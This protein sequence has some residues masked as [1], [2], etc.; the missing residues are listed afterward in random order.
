[1]S[2]TKIREPRI[3]IEAEVA[4][5]FTYASF[6]NAIP[7]LQA[8]RIGNSTSVA[9]DGV[10]TLEAKP[11]FLCSKSWL[12]DR[13]QA[14][15]SFAIHDRRVELDPSYLDGLNEAERGELAF[16][17][18]KDGV[19]LAEWA[20]PIRLLARDEW[21]GASDMAQL[22]PAFV[23]PNDP[24]IATI[25]K[26]AADLL[27]KA[28]HR[29][30]LDGYQSHDPNRVGMMV[31]AVYVAV[32]NRRLH[33]AEPPASFEQY[34]QKI[35]RPSVI[36]RDGLATCLDSSLLLASAFE[37]AGL[38]SMVL[39][40]ERHAAVGAWLMPRTL[41]RAVE[42]DASE[43]RKAVAA[44][45]L[46]ILE[47]TGV[48]QRPLVSMKN[49]RTFA[50]RRISESMAK[51][52]V[53]AIDIARSR[54][55]GI[56]PL[57]SH[58]MPTSS[59]T[60]APE[61]EGKLLPQPHIEVAP[62][63]ASEPKPAT[64]AGRM[65]RWRAK[66][67][68]LSLRNRLLNFVQSKK[69]LP[70]LC[71]DIASL[72]DQLA[73]G[74]AIRIISLPEQ[75]PLG[76]RD[77][78]FYR[79]TRR[80]DLNES[81]ATDALK[82]NE[83][84][85]PLEGT[86]LEARL[87]SLY[88]EAKGDLS[89]GGTNTLFLA[90]GFLRWR[91]PE[92]DRIYSAPL[93][94]IPVK[95]DRKAASSRFYLKEHE[96]E[97]RFNA[98]LAQFLERD[99]QLRLSS[100]DPL[101]RDQSGIDVPKVLAQIRHEIR[102]VPG[103]EVVDEVALSTF[104]FAKYLMWKDLTDRVAALRENRLVKHLIDSP[105]Q[106]F[107][108]DGK[109]F[110]IAEE[111]DRHYSPADILTPLPAD[112]SQVAAILA[113]AEGK[114][115][116]LIGPP[117]TGKSQTITNMIASCLAAGKTVLFV[118][119]KT[120]ALDVVYRRLKAQGLSRHC[121]ELHSNKSDRKHFLAQLKTAWIGENET[122]ADGW[123]ALTNGL[124]LQR[125]KLNSYADAAHRRAPNGLSV[126]EALG[127][128]LEASGEHAPE[129]RWP[130]KDAHDPET[131]AKLETLAASLG[132][133][134]QAVQASDALVEVDVVEWTLAL[135]QTIVAELNAFMQT[136]DVLK[137]ALQAFVATIGATR[138]ADPSLTGLQRYANFAHT[139]KN[140]ASQNFA[141]I[142]DRQFGQLIPAIDALQ[143]ALNQYRRCE[144]DLAAR[145]S[146]DVL[147]RIPTDQ[148]EQQWHEAGSS[149]WLMSWRRK[150]KIKKLL[151]SYAISG[152]SDPLRDLPLIREMQKTITGVQTNP[153]GR[154]QTHFRGLDT[155]A[156]NLHRYLQEAA[157]L[158]DSLIEIGRIGGDV[159]ALASRLYPAFTSGEGYDGLQ[160]S[161]AQY[162]QAH[163]Q[164]K[165]SALRLREL[166]GGD[167]LSAE[168]NALLS[169]SLARVGRIYD[170]RHKLRDWASW[171]EFKRKANAVGL[172]PLI[173]ALETG[174]VKPEESLKAFKLGYRRWWLPL[175]MDD[176]PP[177]RDFREFLHQNTVEEFCR[178]DDL[179]CEQAT[180]K[181]IR[182]LNPGLP[183]PQ[184]VPRQ[185]ELGILRHQMTL[186]RPSR[187]IREMV[188]AMPQSFTRLARCVLMS[189]LS[190][191]QYLP[192]NQALFDVVIFDEASQ[193]T[194]W[195]AVGA[196]ARGRQTIIV[197]DPKQLPPTNFFGRNDADED[198]PDH[199]QD[200]ESILDEVKASGIPAL[201][202][203]WHYR[204][205]HESLIAFSNHY[206]Y[207]DEL[208]TFP[209]PMT[210]DRAVSLRYIRD[211]V[212]GRG[213][214]RA[215]KREAES[216]V[217]EV[218]TRLVSYLMLPEKDRPSVG[219]VTFNI[220]QQNLVEDLLDA[221]R[222]KRPE[223]E[224]FFDSDRIEPVSV[225]NLENV[226]GDERDIM[227]F[228]TTYGKDVEGRLLMAFGAL[229]QA[230]GERR[231]NVAVTRARQE[232]LVFSSMKADDID[233]SRSQ[234]RGVGDF[235]A[236]LDY[237]ERGVA[238][239]ASRDGGSTG[240][241]ESPF[242]VAVARVL[243][244]RG[245]QIV[246]QVGVS[247]FRVD[248]GI[249][250][251]DR[252]GTYLAGI[253]CDGYTY[254]RCPTARDRDKVREQILRGLGWQI[255][256]IWSTD[257]W[258]NSEEAADRL[259]QQLHDLLT[260]SR[261]AE[262]SKEGTSQPI[263]AAQKTELEQGDEVMN[264]SYDAQNNGKIPSSGA[265]GDL[266]RLLDQIA[267]RAQS[268]SR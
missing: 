105:D 166:L 123:I 141:V 11:P 230:G 233:I 5:S 35:R 46:V 167:V 262:L 26:S 182:D 171:C 139:I 179:V 266:Q 169:E 145:Y 82:R 161:A 63:S 44:R 34:G 126:F 194:T 107:P 71:P 236:F 117:G 64:P 138:V 60:D 148:L 268:Q 162:L 224:W 134:F 201:G 49:A 146:R 203:R 247:S 8:L 261:H 110:P 94:L 173:S 198:T 41:S 109:A 115:F 160:R 223:I 216:V 68:D 159:K 170:S 172:K 77:P 228:S 132:V 87:I 214:S 212:Y 33:Y 259:H 101:P 53:V 24:A 21:G 248:L 241:F 210:D 231:L 244:S 258:Y 263:Q 144:Q 54:G 235:K 205:R 164:F 32:A 265:L 89:E 97:A 187:S 195:D 190:I 188:G 39:L 163:S 251:P 254:H 6:Q 15:S 202:L 19:V 131:L 122:R 204:S 140:T 149:F 165:Q 154:V 18:T 158:R 57:A 76:N 119:E 227:M 240:D 186:Q 153:L 193:I 130:T 85:S 208:I 221:E 191:A 209:S 3:S 17:F 42:N 31:Q 199:L 152:A 47:S 70:F 104:S 91:R 178:L 253:E 12:I 78:E 38:H 61:I 264:G 25:L 232:L 102:D 2:E 219:V 45:E 234:A 185:S 106:A 200:L 267:T 120:A 23:M 59:K 50:E 155:D 189:P 92:E 143:H 229:N 90:T 128:T 88:R 249:K 86:E 28:G 260:Y 121:L 218:V 103:F 116:V 22:L 4:G 197:G 226:Q 211:G 183:S 56:R 10:L 184:Q 113:A 51:E 255:L 142:Y 81:F 112:S 220:Q 135:Q 133:V 55:N 73:A 252:A 111:L 79:Q 180:R 181:I 7:I 40:F 58:E 238:A 147:A 83:I 215:N 118:A 114:D 124:K 48:T 65:E 66:L 93:L 67:L 14:E 207:D 9:A 30:A 99:F 245:W 206:Y 20:A 151:Q 62:T 125:D 150:R 217:E 157:A 176:D 1:M 177:L 27:E 156:P 237:A 72:E 213:T 127:A 84:A 69:T 100:F 250:H 246:P 137:S 96:D 37:A 74:A 243:E 174:L 36:L 95:L 257:W 222:R 75:N 129:L 239:I 80:Q 256:R 16:R 175:A 108:S 196:I 43:L 225:R 29:S 168:S 52:F 13:V 98:T 242:E 136:A 192:T